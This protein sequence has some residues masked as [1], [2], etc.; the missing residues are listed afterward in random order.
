MPRRLLVEA[1]GGSRGNPGPA[2]YGA[3]VRDRDTGE[4]LAE[5]ADGIGIATNNVAEYRGLIAGLGAARE[6]AERDDVESVQVRLDSKLV[7]E[8]MT[9][10]WKVKHADMQ[11]L[12]AE[13]DAL[14]AQLPQVR[15]AHHARVLNSHADRL[16]NE[17]MDAAARGT[18][19][20]RDTPPAPHSAAGWTR[21][22][23][24]PTTTL[25]VR[26]AQTGLSAEKRFSGVGDVPLNEVGRAETE[27][28]ARRI[29]ESADR[30]AAVWSSPLD[31]ARTTATAIARALDLS[32]TEHSGL[33]EVDFGA[34]EGLTLEDVARDWPELFAQW[35]AGTDVAPPGGESFRAAAAR[36]H[37]AAADV[38]AKNPEA[39]VV[40]VSHVTPLKLL[41]GSALRAE[42]T[43][44]YRVYLEPA[45]VSIV[46]W[47]DD[48]FAVVR[49]VN[50]TCHLDALR[51]QR[52]VDRST[53]GS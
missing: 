24:Q 18:S 29:A 1:D 43:A 42:T 9:G 34:W 21:T 31:R 40:V 25:L 38:I 46:D 3:V 11:R 32:V 33:R 45:S 20:E 49:A 48:G 8:Q 44:L 39:T 4:V 35:S 51:A 23:Q 12:K 6:I 13:A 50:D 22:A 10:R 36:V 16:A 19:W 37:A 26:H 14:V 15:W 47:Y 5:V 7:V 2:G 41:L 52:L 27:A 17:A 30:I 53:V 28:L